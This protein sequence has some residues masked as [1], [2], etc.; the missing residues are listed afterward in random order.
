MLCGRKSLSHP[1]L[2]A[3]SRGLAFFGLVGGC[4]LGVTCLVAFGVCVS[5]SPAGFVFFRLPFRFFLE[6][7]NVRDLS[8][9]WCLES[10]VAQRSRFAV[11]GS[12]VCLVAWY[13]CRSFERH[14]KLARPECLFFPSGLRRGQ[15]DVVVFKSWVLLSKQTTRGMHFATYLSIIGVSPTLRC[16]SLASA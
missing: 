11:Y 14:E 5:L 7:R 6:W 4:R 12:Y 3:L 2:E 16:S 8:R 1:K 13:S 15:T 9:G 10:T